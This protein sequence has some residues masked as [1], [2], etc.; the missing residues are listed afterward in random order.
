M[1]YLPLRHL[2]TS[3]R[4]ADCR[5]DQGRRGYRGFFSRDHNQDHYLELVG[6]TSVGLLVSNINYK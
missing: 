3:S 6:T 2:I 5:T 4:C 1:T